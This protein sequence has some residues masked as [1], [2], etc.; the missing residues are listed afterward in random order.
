MV[1]Y[2]EL[3]EAAMAMPVPEQITLK[4]PKDFRIIGHAT[5]RIDAKAKSSG[6]QDFGIDMHLP[7]QLTAVVAR[8]PVFGAKIASL[9]DSA[10]RAIKGVKAVLRVPLDGG[11]E[12]VAVV[13]DG[14][15]QAKLARDALKVEWNSTTVEKVDSEK[16]L[17]Q[18]RK[19]VRQPG[20]RQFDADMTPLAT[21]PEGP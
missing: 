12:G 7:G 6:L 21:A 17:A 9:D 15:W 13:A 19:L 10:A 5:T 1:S 2:G 16:Q 3:A 20:P 8:P 14:Y 18:Y 11:A 4:D